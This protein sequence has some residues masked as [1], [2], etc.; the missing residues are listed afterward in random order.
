MEF[1]KVGPT[2]VEKRA[3]LLEIHKRAGVKHGPYLETDNKR[4]GPVIKPT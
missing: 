1:T 3:V 2:E 4:P